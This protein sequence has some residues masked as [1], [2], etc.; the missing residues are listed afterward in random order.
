MRH[1]LVLVAVAATALSQG[2]V[3]LHAC[4]DKLMMLGRR[5]QSKHAPRAASVLCISHRAL[6][7]DL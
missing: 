1:L 2:S 4:G 6:Q 7:D 5:V 3:P